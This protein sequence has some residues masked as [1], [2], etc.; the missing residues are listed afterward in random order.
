MDNS[1]LLYT[2]VV[3]RQEHTKILRRW[4]A[5]ERLHHDRVHTGL[6]RP[7]GLSLTLAFE[8]YLEGRRRD[9]DK[10]IKAARGRVCLEGPS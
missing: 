9:L 10:Q 3:L 6:G 7:S 2:A 1:V 4:H 8:K 5:L